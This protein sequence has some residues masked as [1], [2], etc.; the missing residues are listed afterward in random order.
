MFEA[1]PLAVHHCLHQVTWPITSWELSC[2]RPPHLTVEALG[3]Q[4]CAI[5]A[6]FTRV[7][8][9]LC[10]KCLTHSAIIPEIPMVQ[11][12]HQLS[13]LLNYGLQCAQAAHTP[14]AMPFPAMMDYLPS[15]IIS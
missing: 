7:W 8:G 5:T 2:L 10:N 4:K 14:A 3:L 15:Q 9:I 12:T 6:N 11:D 13:V 1:A